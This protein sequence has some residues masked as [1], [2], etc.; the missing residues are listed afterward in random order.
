MSIARTLLI[1]ASRSTWL[2]NQ[3]RHRAFARRAVQRLMP[4]EDLEAALGAAA[5]LASGGIGTVLTQLG[6]QVRSGAEAEAVRDHYRGV[7]GQVRER[8][9]PAHVSVKLTHL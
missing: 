5:Q 8:F 7:L 6:E 3:F 4:G 1:R 9:L 2:A